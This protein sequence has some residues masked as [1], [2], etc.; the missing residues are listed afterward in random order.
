MQRA[1]P[2]ADRLANWLPI[3]KGGSFRATLR[4]YLPKPALLSGQFHFSPLE[5]LS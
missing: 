2:Q 3:P 4:A 1:T 5:R